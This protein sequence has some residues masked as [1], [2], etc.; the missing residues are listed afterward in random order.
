M[1]GLGAFGAAALYHCALRG[2]RVCGLEAHP[3][4]HSYG[5]SHGHTRII[6][7]AY[8]EVSQTPIPTLNPGP[9]TLGSSRES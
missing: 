2:L 3:L 7:L 6:R 1:V 9:W 8:H 4:G 5:S